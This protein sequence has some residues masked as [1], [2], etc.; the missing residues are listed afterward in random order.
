MVVHGEVGFTLLGLLHRGGVRSRG[1]RDRDAATVR[2]RVRVR[3]RVRVTA[4]RGFTLIV[5]PI[6]ALALSSAVSRADGSRR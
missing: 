3:G 5:V 6:A 1:H 4:R 2:M